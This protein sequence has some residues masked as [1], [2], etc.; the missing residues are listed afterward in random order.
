MTPVI[1]L[2]LDGLGLAPPGPGNAVYLANPT[3]FNSLLY[4]YPNTTLK[5]SGQ[6]VGL[7]AD[8]VGNTEVGHLNMGA[9]KI[10]YQDLPRI[11][12][13]IADGTFYKNDILL[14]GMSQVKNNNSKLHLLG[15]LS[16]GTVHSSLEHL[17]ALIYLAKEQNV[18]NLFVHVIT[19]GRDSP[20]KSAEDEIKK[21]DQKLR[22]L[23]IG[24]I[25][26]V[27]GGYYA[28]D[29]DR[30][31]ERT[32]KAYVCLTTGVG[33]KAATPYEAVQNSYKEG[34]T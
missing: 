16:E 2:V 31:W 19:D 34:K 18:T 10:V 20:P 30:R 7:P 6:A 25:A 4:S 33:N 15:L 5:A 26:S 1:L 27:M 8:E 21:L 32:E 29:R 23:G 12:M 22:D 13:A 3:N 28:M 24:T 9:G 11:N 17:Y 14:A